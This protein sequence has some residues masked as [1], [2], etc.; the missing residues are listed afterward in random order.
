MTRPDLDAQIPVTAEEM[1]DYPGVDHTPAPRAY[2]TAEEFGAP[3]AWFLLGQD[4][5]LAIK[6][7]LSI[8]T[9]AETG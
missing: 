9:P 4:K 7:G 1:R 3:L 6:A 5:R 8:G 2:K